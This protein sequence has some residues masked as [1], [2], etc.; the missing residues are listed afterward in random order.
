MRVSVSS[1]PPR[2]AL[3]GLTFKTE[4]QAKDIIAGL[5][6]VYGETTRHLFAER[7]EGHRDRHR[8][9][10]GRHRSD[11]RRSAGGEGL[12]R[13]PRRV[14]RPGDRCPISTGQAVTQAQATLTG[15][16]LQL[17][18]KLIPDNGCTG[19]N[20]TA[21]SLVGEQPQKSTVELDLLRRLIGPISPA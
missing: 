14:E 2:V 7:A 21:Q 10:A 1:G 4:Q 8:A 3:V 20:V 17:T 5:E 19:Q 18:V 15:S 11:H 9:A 6:L 13:Q 12:D 16:A